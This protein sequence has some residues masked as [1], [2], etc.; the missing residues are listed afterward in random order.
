MSKY[1]LDKPLKQKIKQLNLAFL[2]NVKITRQ[3]LTAA[4]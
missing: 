1:S 3:L 2:Q 4:F